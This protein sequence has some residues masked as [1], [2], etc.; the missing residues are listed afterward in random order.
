MRMLSMLAM[1]ALLSAAAPVLADQDSLD[2]ELLEGLG[3]DLFEGLDIPDVV[4]P[5]PSENKPDG[6]QDPP[7]NE[8]LIGEPDGEDLGEGPENPLLQIGRD[9]QTVQDRIGQGQAEDDTLSMQQSIIKQ[10]DDL[11]EQA[12]QQQQQQQQQQNPQQ[13]QQQQQQKNQQQQQQ[14]QQ[15]QQ[16]QQQGQ[17]GQQGQQQPQN[18]GAEPQPQEGDAEQQSQQQRDNEQAME[19]SDELRDKDYELLP[20][21][22]R[23]ALIKEVWG[24]LPER[25]RQQLQN[26]SVEKFLPKYERLTEDY[27]R[28]LAEEEQGR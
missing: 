24:Q 14:N 19:S 11:I 9:M 23:G 4:P 27:F 1:C 26:A 25:V 7:G 13:Q 17:Q 6:S 22:A 18:G 8:P 12:K 28:R 16:S 2:Q 10:L 21:E 20:L 15:Q 3:D 5:K